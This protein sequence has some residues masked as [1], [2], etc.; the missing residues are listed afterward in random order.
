MKDGNSSARV[1]SELYSPPWVGIHRQKL[2][3]A[4]EECERQQQMSRSAASPSPRRPVVHG[5]PRH[6][7]TAAPGESAPLLGHGQSEW[8]KRWFA[9]EA[10]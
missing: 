3:A 2:G 5:P 7:R 9:A 10:S 4:G 6:H 1:I 8:K